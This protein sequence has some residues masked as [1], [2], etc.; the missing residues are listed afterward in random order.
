MTQQRLATFLLPTMLLALVTS[1]SGCPAGSGTFVFFQDAAL[2]S[3]VRA[4]AGKPLGLLTQTDVL[5]ITEVDASGLNIQTLDGIEALRNLTVLDLR[6]NNVRSI[7]KLENLI[8]L[9]VLDLGDNNVAQI[10]ALSGLFL[11]EELT[12]SGGEMDIVDWSPLSA[13]ATNGGLGAGD[14]V[15]LPVNTTLDTDGNVLNYWEGDYLTLL[16]LGVSVLFDEMGTTN[17]ETA[18]N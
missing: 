6:T 13:N 11:L 15:T 10:T 14:V 4:A 17:D 8:N 2:E 16:N 18:T 12:L 9:R 3:A 1:L 7:T 5:A